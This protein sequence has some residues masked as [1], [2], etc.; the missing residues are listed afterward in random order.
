MTSKEL[1]ALLDGNQYGY[2]ITAEQ[3]RLANEHNLV[4][5]FGFSDDIVELC[6]K[7]YDEVGVL[8][9]RT[10]LVTRYGVMYDPEWICERCQYFMAA[11][12]KAM[13]IRAVWNI[14]GVAAWTFETQ[15]PHETFRIFD[16]EELFCIGIVFDVNDLPL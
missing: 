7:I 1:A 2:E 3:K 8:N 10:F 16:G 9:G 11:R 4:V 13:S 14:T 12:K 5:V 15:I 6:G